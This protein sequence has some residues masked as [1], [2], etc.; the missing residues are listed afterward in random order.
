MYVVCLVVVMECKHVTSSVL[1]FVVLCVFIQ[2]RRKQT[3][4]QENKTPTQSCISLSS[5]SESAILMPCL[6]S[7]LRLRSLSLLSTR[8]RLLH[9]LELDAVVIH[10]APRRWSRPPPSG[11]WR[12]SSTQHHL[13]FERVFLEVPHFGAQRQA[14]LILCVIMTTRPSR[15]LRRC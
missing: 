11:S 7:S 10:R 5:S 13:D 2:S 14:V 8:Q 12:S 1:L 4:K 15:A 3:N 6:A 9:C